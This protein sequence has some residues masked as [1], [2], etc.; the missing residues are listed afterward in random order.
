MFFAKKKLVKI[1]A[2]NWPTLEEHIQNCSEE[3]RE[4]TAK[5]RE[6]KKRIF[7][8]KEEIKTKVY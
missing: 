1:I 7:M 5:E 2:L 8:D 4:L 6:I 3:E